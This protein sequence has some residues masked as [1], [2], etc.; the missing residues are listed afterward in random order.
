MVKENRLP[1]LWRECV[2]V[3]VCVCV[4]RG[5]NVLTPRCWLRGW[6]GAFLMRRKEKGSGRKFTFCHS[7]GLCELFVLKG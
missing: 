3:C 7:S 6:K 4:G 2:R 5:G 1:V